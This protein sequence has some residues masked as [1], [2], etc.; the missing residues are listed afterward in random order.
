MKSEEG[1][2]WVYMFS[3][4]VEQE[5]MVSICRDGSKM[6]LARGYRT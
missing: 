3:Q 2:E 6:F 4:G 1:V 5:E